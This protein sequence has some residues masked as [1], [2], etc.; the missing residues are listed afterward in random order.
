VA[1]ESVSIPMPPST[2]AAMVSSMPGDEG[3]LDVLDLV[4]YDQSQ[5]V[6][7]WARDAATNFN[8]IA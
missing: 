2:L 4:V 3:Q 7:W 1:G 5:Q 6:G 8:C